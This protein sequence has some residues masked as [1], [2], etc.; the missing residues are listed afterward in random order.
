MDTHPCKDQLS[1]CC[2]WIS[3]QWWPWAVNLVGD[4]LSAKKWFYVVQH[5]PP[6]APQAQCLRG[7]FVPDAPSLKWSDSFPGK[8]RSMESGVEREQCAVRSQPGLSTPMCTYLPRFLLH[9]MYLLPTVC[10]EPTRHSGYGMFS[11]EQKS[12]EISSR[13]LRV[14]W[15]GE[16]TCKQTQSHH[17]Q[18]PAFGRGG[19]TPRPMS[20]R[21]YSSRAGCFAICRLH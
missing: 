5:R 8:K 12:N 4:T 1:R 14:Y 21:R 3:D 13:V 7:F 20:R 9:A 18:P 16:L 11:C 19:V 2:C 6:K 10:T 17:V 15:K